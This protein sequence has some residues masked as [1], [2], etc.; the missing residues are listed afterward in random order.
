MIKITSNFDVIMTND[1]KGNH[2]LYSLCRE[3]LKEVS[4]AKYLGIQI[5]SKLASKHISLQEATPT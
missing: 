1:Q 4:D 2:K 5:D 3:I